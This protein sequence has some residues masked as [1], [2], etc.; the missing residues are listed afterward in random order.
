MTD[1]SPAP[2]DESRPEPRWVLPLA[3]LGI[4]VGSSVA[5]FF[6]FRGSGCVPGAVWGII[7]GLLARWLI[8]P[9][10]KLA[11]RLQEVIR[12]LLFTLVLLLLTELISVILCLWLGKV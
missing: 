12:I 2:G 6:G 3:V 1:P 5:E 4:V 8:K 10:S 7:L 9:E 11:N